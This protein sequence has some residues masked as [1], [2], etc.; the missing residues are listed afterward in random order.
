MYAASL[1]DGR[2]AY[3][4]HP[5]PSTDAE[6]MLDVRAA[7]RALGLVAIEHALM[8]LGADGG[9]AL[10][11][12]GDSYAAGSKL[13]ATATLCILLQN[14]GVGGGVRDAAAEAASVRAPGSSLPSSPSSSLAAVAAA[15][16]PAADQLFAADVFERVDPQLEAAEE[17]LR[18]GSH[19]APVSA[20]LVR[21]APPNLM[22]LGG[23]LST[24]SK[25][26]E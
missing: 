11:A 23:W 16:A 20:V 14:G 22:E 5:C 7:P 3:R 26:F 25:K 1:A 19:G 2:A 6:Y 9:D 18:W 10:G 4:P 8:S 15:P 24:L 17:V 21:R 12:A 13:G